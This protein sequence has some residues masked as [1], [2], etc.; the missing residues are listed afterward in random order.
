MLYM[1]ILVL[2]IHVFGT[3]YVIL[4]I[5]CSNAIQDDRPTECKFNF[6]SLLEFKLHIDISFYNNLIL[7]VDFAKII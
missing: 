5:L 4:N 7:I 2:N 1:N 3:I 6:A